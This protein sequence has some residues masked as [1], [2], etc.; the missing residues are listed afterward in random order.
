MK[1]IM[2]AAAPFGYGPAARALLIADALAARG[3][4]T[5]FTNR[6]AMRFV[7]RHADPAVT[8]I[9]GVFHRSFA[10]AAELGR[11][12]RFISV[13]NEPAVHH[14]IAHGLAGRTVFVDSLLEWRA[15]SGS[16]AFG[17]AILGYLVQDFPGAA[18]RLGACRARHVAL[19]APM[20]WN[21][22]TRCRVADTAARGVVLHL[23]GVTSPLVGWDAL[24]EPIATIVDQAWRISSRHGRSLTVVGSRHLAS[25]ASDDP[26]GPRILAESSP[27]DTASLICGSE[28]LL[29]TPGI[30]AVYEA[31]TRA[32][33]IV[34][35][36]AT[37]STQLRHYGVYADS[38]FAGSIPDAARERLRSAADAMPWERQTAF[39]VGWLRANPALALGR[40]REHVD[41]VL[42]P[43]TDGGAARALMLRRQSEFLAA[44]SSASAIEQLEQLLG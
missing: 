17:E 35:L 20:V 4:V 44:L 33:P 24:R 32:V 13:N 23:G 22:S 43:E 10:S 7:R 36:P 37:N 41:S 3:S 11:F 16:G 6:D 2:I 14:L 8:C 5:L 26:A 39:S 42:Q 21:A 27:W 19:T 1:N 12:D 15:L 18:A 9:E 29:T 34:M 25:L 38:G 30:G 28:L 31:I 40:L